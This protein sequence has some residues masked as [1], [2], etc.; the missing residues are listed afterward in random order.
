MLNIATPAKMF[1]ISAL[2]FVPMAGAAQTAPTIDGTVS[3]STTAIDVEGSDFRLNAL[4][5]VTDINFSNSFSIGL[6]LDNGRQSLAD[7]IDVN[8]KRVQ[9]EPTWTFE[10]GAYVGAY[11]QTASTDVSILSV[12]LDNVGVFGGY[13][14]ERWSVDAYF[15]ETSTGFAMLDEAEAT[16]AGLTFSANPTENLEL[17]GHHARADLK[18]SGSAG[19]ITLSALG[20]EYN[21]DN[22]LMTYAAA[23]TFEADF[24]GDTTLQHFAI[25]GGAQ[26]SKLGLNA[27]GMLT[28]ELAKTDGDSGIDQN[29][30]TLGWVFGIGNGDAT[31]LNGIARIARGGI[32]GPFVGGIGAF[33]FGEG[34]SPI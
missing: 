7:G 5:V 18:G 22:G 9:I 6:D 28:L 14:Q 24:F 16:N 12:T 17:F 19:D 31:P 13:A 25:G 21:Y 23:G 11:F 8:M 26:L 20:A 33:G 15:G 30:V 32:R 2:I 4:N 10:N 1:A 34:F 3:I 29:Q 27:P